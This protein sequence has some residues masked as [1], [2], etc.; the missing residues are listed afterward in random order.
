MV[1]TEAVEVGVDEDDD[2]ETEDEELEGSV[3]LDEEESV[4]G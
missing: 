1:E 2:F 4:V 3:M